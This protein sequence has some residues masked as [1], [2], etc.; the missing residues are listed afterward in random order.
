MRAVDLQSRILARK[1]KT[2]AT[3][4]PLELE[5]IWKAMLVTPELGPILRRKRI[6]KAVVENLSV[7]M[8]DEKD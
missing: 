8:L 2:G 4:G 3:D 6:R 5:V 1:D 7:L